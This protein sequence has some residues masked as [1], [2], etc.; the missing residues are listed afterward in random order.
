MKIGDIMTK[1]VVCVKPEDTVKTAA[2][3]M[4]E[5]DIGSVPVCDENK[6]IGIVTDRDIVLRVISE[7]K[8]CNCVKVRDVMTSNPVVGSPNMKVEEAARIMGERQIRRLPIEE[9][10]KFVGMVSL[11]DIAVEPSISHKANDALCEISEPCCPE[12]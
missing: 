3:S 7:E 11:G 1:S 5:H 6:I 8:D 4:K 12:V 9:N 2:C 10:N